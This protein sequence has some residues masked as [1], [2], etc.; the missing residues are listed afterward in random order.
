MPKQSRSKCTWVIKEETDNVITIE[1]GARPLKVHVT[2][3]STRLIV[4]DNIIWPSDQDAGFS[5]QG[6]QVKTTGC[7]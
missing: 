3:E 4:N 5:F 7:L 6:S 2:E 1:Q